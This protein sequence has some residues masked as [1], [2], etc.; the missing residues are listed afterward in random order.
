MEICCTTGQHRGHIGDVV[1]EGGERHAGPDDDRVDQKHVAAAELAEDARDRVDD[2]RLGDAADDNKEARQKQQRLV[3][4]LLQRF[5]KGVGVSLF[6]DVRDE[7][8]EEHA[9]AD[10]AVG[11]A[12]AVREEADPDQQQHRAREQHGRQIVRDDGV[13]LGLGF[14]LVT[15]EEPQQHEGREPRADL[16]DEEHAGASL[17]PEEVHEVHVRRAAEQDA[18][19]VAHQGGRALQVGGHGDRD[20]HRHGRD[21]ELLRDGEGHRRDHEHGRD[22]VHER[23]HDAREQAQ[24][25]DRG[26]HGADLVQQHVRHQRRHAR[27]DEDGDQAHRAG[28]HHQHVPVDRAQDRARA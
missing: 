26:A 22:V 2:A 17:E 10:D 25:D 11:D 9:H 8:D 16:H 3:V 24:G 19:G 1:D 6:D 7:A 23:G 20:D 13:L 15:A 5:Y 18:G 28:D 21:V 12:R 27:V 4:D 14:L